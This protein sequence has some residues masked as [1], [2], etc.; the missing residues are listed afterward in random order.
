MRCMVRIDRLQ[1]MY[2]GSLNVLHLLS[3][4]M[5]LLNELVH[6]ISLIFQNHLQLW[7]LLELLY[8]LLE[9]IPLLE[10]YI[11]SI[12]VFPV[13]CLLFSATT[14]A[15]RFPNANCLSCTAFTCC[16]WPRS[17]GLITCSRSCWLPSSNI[18][19]CRYLSQR[20]VEEVTY[21]LKF[22]LYVIMLSHARD[23]HVARHS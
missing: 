12:V 23:Q 15:G 4:P 18:A 10:V 21:L 13:F 20:L 16:C 14:L 17:L 2:H 1:G 8:H 3:D 11:S 9:D 6:Y 22:I 19:S 5:G 7:W